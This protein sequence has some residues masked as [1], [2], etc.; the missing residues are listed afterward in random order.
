MTT[1]FAFLNYQ[2]HNVRTQDYPVTQFAVT[3]CTQMRV[4]GVILGVVFFSSRHAERKTLSRIHTLG[5]TKE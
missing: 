5:T 3:Q 1:N 4:T 2:L